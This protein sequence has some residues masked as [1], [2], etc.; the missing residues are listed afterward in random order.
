VSTLNANVNLVKP[1]A[2]MLTL[3]SPIIAVPSY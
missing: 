1:M 2:Q 3:I